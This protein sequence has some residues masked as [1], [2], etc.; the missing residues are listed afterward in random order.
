M[1]PDGLIIHIMAKIQNGKVGLWCIHDN[2][3]KPTYG[4]NSD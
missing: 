4:E 2:I 1:A 3:L